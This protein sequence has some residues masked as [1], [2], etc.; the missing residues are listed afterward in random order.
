LI[1]KTKRDL[2]LWDGYC[3]VH[4]I[5]SFKELI[6]AQLR[7]PLAEVIAHPECKEEILDLADFIGSTAALINYTQTSKS[8][9][10]II[11][12]E[13]GVIHQMKK[14]NSNKNYIPLSNLKGCSC[15]EC[16]YMRLNTLDKM[17]QSLKTLKPEINLDFKII[18]KA[19]KPLLKMLELSW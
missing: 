11:A 19:K 1:K 4:A 12:T 14:I 6:K 3:E 16:P 17:I 9:E 2:I 8:D 5:F 10:F 13:P 15:N 18:E 7:H